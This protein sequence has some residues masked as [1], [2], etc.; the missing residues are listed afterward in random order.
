[1][2][3]AIRKDNQGEV[4]AAFKASGNPIKHG[5]ARC[6]LHDDETPS[7]SVKVEGERLFVHCYAGCDQNE[8][9]TAARRLVDDH[10]GEYRSGASIGRVVSFPKQHDAGIREDWLGFVE[11]IGQG[12]GYCKQKGVQR[13]GLRVDKNGHDVVPMVSDGGIG[14]EVVGYQSLTIG[15]G[16]KNAT[17]SAKKGSAYIIGR[18]SLKEGARIIVCEGYATAAT[19]YEAIGI[20]AACAFGVGNVLSVLEA[21]RRHGYDAICGCDDDEKG[22]E[23]EDEAR[24]LGFRAIR[25]SFDSIHLRTKDHDDWNDLATLKSIEAVREQIEVQLSAPFEPLPMEDTAK[26]SKGKNKKAAYADYQE[27]V[28]Q[29]FPQKP[30]RKDLIS[31]RLCVF[32]RNQWL[33]IASEGSG[34]LAVVQSAVCDSGGFYSLTPLTKHLKAWEHSSEG[35]L[36]LDVADWDGEER[37]K[38]LADCLN[39]EVFEKAEV[40]EL[41]THWLITALRKARDPKGK[42]S[43]NMVLVFQGAQGIGKDRFIDVILNIFRGPANYVATLL[44]KPNTSERDW[45]EVLSSNILVSIPE[46]DRLQSQAVSTFKHLV[47]A[48]EATWDRKYE[49]DPVT[50][51]VRASIVASINPKEVASD[52]TGARR[53][54]LIELKGKP[55]SKCGKDETPA[56]RWSYADVS[57]PIQL[58]A[59]VVAKEKSWLGLSERTIKKLEEVQQRMTPSDEVEDAIRE[60]FDSVRGSPAWSLNNATKRKD[61]KG[62]PCLFIPTPE[63]RSALND[64]AA[65]YGLSANTLRARLGVEGYLEKESIR[66]APGSKTSRGCYIPIDLSRTE[67]QYKEISEDGYGPSMETAFQSGLFGGQSTPRSRTMWSEDD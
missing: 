34:P 39:A 2:S 57:D 36:L 29:Q 22:K 1:M 66:Y 37:L 4:E 60:F 13:Y 62:E 40:Y 11:A 6:L 51:S 50:K 33:P 35:E 59:E 3:N 52:P 64:A 17:G 18:D 12:D 23:A 16:K 45:G 7:M 41:L 32:D 20:P 44:I 65:K 63:T 26:K 38:A 53:Y 48:T 67:A 28:R 5:K 15:A 9:F 14:G 8:L 21:L 30:P 42:A 55:D 54:L 58:L 24:Q 61:V 47:T 43:Q 49:A 27:L 46:F 31:G 56:I 25:P 10:R 19:V